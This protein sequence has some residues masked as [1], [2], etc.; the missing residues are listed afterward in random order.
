MARI[1]SGGSKSTCGGI[2]CKKLLE[3]QYV[4]SYLLDKH[5]LQIDIPADLLLYCDSLLIER[6][7]T[8][9]LENVVKYT[10]SQTKLGI[11][12]YG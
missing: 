12:S 6:V 3:V 7:L 10:V 4:H 1:Q 9:L 5:P 2:Y 11:K 8:N